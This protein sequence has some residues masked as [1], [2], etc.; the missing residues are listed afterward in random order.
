MK[1]AGET[2]VFGRLLGRLATVASRRERAR[3]TW[4]L[5]I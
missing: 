2:T 5:L 3:Q 4:V 1:T